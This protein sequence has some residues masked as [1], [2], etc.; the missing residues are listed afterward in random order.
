[1]RYLSI[2]GRKTDTYV[3]RPILLVLFVFVIITIVTVTKTKYS[4]M[5]YTA[6]VRY[7]TKLEKRQQGNIC[8]R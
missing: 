8:G 2:Q 7:Q 5:L 3:C 4:Q 1:M 6:W